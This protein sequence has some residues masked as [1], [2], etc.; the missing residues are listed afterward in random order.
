MRR[1]KNEIQS[2]QEAGFSAE[3]TRIDMQSST[4]SL[5]ET[6]RQ[7]S[8]GRRIVGVLA[9]GL[10]RRSSSHYS[11]TG[12]PNSPSLLVR[13]HFAFP[14]LAA[15]AVAA[16]GL[17]LLLPGGALHAQDAAIE[18]AENGTGPVATYTAVDPEGA[19]IRWSLSGLDASDFSIEDGVLSF[20]K[21]PNYEKATGG[22]STAAN[23]LSTYNV[24]VVATDATRNSKEKKVIVSVTNVEEAG[25]VTMS[26]LRPQSTIPF[27]ATLTDPD[28][29]TVGD[30]TGSITTGVTWQWAKAGSKNGSYTDIDKA[31]SS[32]YEP[33]DGDIGS[34]LR[35]TATYTDNEGSD[36]SEMGVSDYAVQSIRGGNRAPAFPVNDPDTDVNESE[37]TREVP[38]NTKAGMAIGDPV[39]AEDKDGDVLTYTLEGTDADEFD[40][41]WATGQL[42][43]KEK[44]DHEASVCD[45]NP[46]DNPTTCT[47]TVVVR[48]T[49]PA[50]IPGSSAAA[51]TTATITVTIMVTG[52]NEAPK[53]TGPAA[54]TYMEL[55]KTFEV[56]G[57][58]A[59]MDYTADD[60][61]T[62]ATNDDDAS[63]WSVSGDDAGKF[64]I[65][66]AGVLTF[67]TTAQPD[68]EKPGD[69]N[70]DDVYE[71]TVGA[72]DSVGNR[73]TRDVKVTV[74]NE[75]EDGVVTLSRTQPRVGVSVK[76][77]LDDPDGSI[78]RLRWKWY[79]A[80]SIN[81][82]SLPSEECSA[83]VVNNCI[84]KDKTSDT[85]TPVKADVGARL[86][87]VASYTDGEDVEKS[88]V[89]T[90]DNDV[91]EDTR[92]LPPAFEDQD[93][94]TKGTQ[95]ETTTREIE[96]N[97]KALA[98][99]AGETDADDDDAAAAA[100]N[101]ADNVGSVITAKDPDP[102]ADPLIYTLSGD[103]A[104][105][106]RVRD[107]GQIEVGAGTKLDYE[108]KD[109]YMVTLTAEDS[110]GG[111]ASIMVTIRVTD[112]NEGPKISVGGLAI[113]GM[114]SVEYAENG[115][116][117][118]AT[119]SASGPESANAMWS[120][121]GDDMGDFRID[122]S[123]GEL[124]FMRAPDYENPADADMNNEYMVTV[125][126]DD[127][128]YMAM[129]EVVVTVTDVDDVTSGDTLVTQYAGV[130]GILQKGEVLMAIN[131]YLFDDATDL[132]KPDVL[133]LINLYLFG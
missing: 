81:V 43:T 63:T 91:N 69:A 118:V 21:S 7:T 16:L 67:K 124:T 33:V 24:T 110:F 40:I 72:A 20:K 11:P 34:Y 133:E 53:V 103:D 49:D 26:A 100:E 112:E 39:V 44:L 4:R 78:S 109:T 48:A 62:S 58:A 113:T 98:G 93:T 94:E 114:I 97:T 41:D 119:Y 54:V 120:L 27:T 30:P 14:M 74:A 102:N 73:G 8:T 9:S 10:G 131:E 35:A 51:G 96:E 32:G 82:G 28:N 132:T 107:N 126:A 52:V 12:S 130:D 85:Y 42:K 95:N 101:D 76:A 83:T 38:E 2:G 99:A 70:M 64:V 79:R 87:A 117:M 50:G 66:P 77:E 90:A 25:T 46:S 108:M 57:S 68:F 116:G 47:Y 59:D 88:A 15:L 36:K 129:R 17:W 92:N 45:Y 5:D 1:D 37:P 23:T 106:F 56:D 3:P 22:G 86:N 121:G 123:S 19:A 31:S 104:G 115:T 128:T 18:Y 80:S 111:T 71:V 60:P 89:G 105:L 127:G 75:E 6:A 122:S 125:M 55:D 61:E 84:L 65:S 13:R 29:V